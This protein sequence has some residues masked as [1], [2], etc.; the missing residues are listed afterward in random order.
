MCHNIPKM[1]NTQHNTCKYFAQMQQPKCQN[2]SINAH[3]N[4]WH[5]Y[6]FILIHVAW[7]YFR[8]IIPTTPIRSKTHHHAPKSQRQFPHKLSKMM[9]YLHT[10][11]PQLSSTEHHI[12]S[13]PCAGDLHPLI[14]SIS[15]NKVIFLPA[16]NKVIFP[17][18]DLSLLGTNHHF[19][20]ETVGY[21][22]W[23]SIT[24]NLH[25][26][27]ASETPKWSRREDVFV[28]PSVASIW[29]LSR[30]FPASIVICAHIWRL[31]PLFRPITPH[32]P[33]DGPK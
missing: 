1:F 20:R 26:I 27:M 15:H 2:P 3:C 29:L 7:P 9:P 4:G 5:I 31:Y 19:P 6:H 23:C 10:C 32:N 12:V 28:F 11:P 30:F 25:L 22:D 21:T 13:H 17:P 18:R 8:R 33:Q 16:H 14:R 24:Y